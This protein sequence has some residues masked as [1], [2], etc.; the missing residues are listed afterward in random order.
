MWHAQMQI[1]LSYTFLALLEKFAES[2]NYLR[3]VCPSV[4]MQQMGI[5]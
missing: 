5:H 4:R 2:D 1:A 3:H